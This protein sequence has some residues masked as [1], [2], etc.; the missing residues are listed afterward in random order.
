MPPETSIPLGRQP[1]R[2]KMLLRRECSRIMN[3]S[4]LT[5]EKRPD[6][7]SNS[8]VGRMVCTAKRYWNLVCLVAIG[9][10]VAPAVQPCLGQ[11]ESQADPAAENRNRSHFSIPPSG[12]PVDPSKFLP[13]HFE[14]ATSASEALSLYRKVMQDPTEY[15]KK[16]NQE[17]LE[18]VA[19]SLLNGDLKLDP[20]DPLMR[21]LMQELNNPDREKLSPGLR[22]QLEIVR[23]NSTSGGTIAPNPIKPDGQQAA[24]YPVGSSQPATSASNGAPSPSSSAQGLSGQPAGADQSAQSGSAL[25]RWL[26]RQAEGLAAKDG[27][28]RNSPSVQRALEEFVLSGSSAP[29]S[30]APDSF[31]EMLRGVLPEDWWSEHASERFGDLESMILSHVALPEFRLPRPA[32]PSADVA[33]GPEDLH[34]SDVPGTGATLLWFLA[35]LALGLGGWSMYRRATIRKEEST[36]RLATPGAWP[37]APEAVRSFEDFIQAF[38]H[39]S[40]V[41]LGPKARNWNHRTIALELGGD[42]SRRQ[43]MAQHLARLYEQARY[44]PRPTRF[45]ADALDVAQSELVSLAGTSN[46]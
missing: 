12:S 40:L 2:G 23:R 13:E 25:N 27:V 20:N 29:S 18:Q 14:H 3:M 26:L 32:L 33:A 42:E 44:A 6:L 22:Q 4:R 36:N 9:A 7:L 1:W 34:I 24:Q 43:Q 30:D 5:L 11:R 38:E 31:S 21:I 10:S 45:A 35:A 17:T 28:L 8:R 41:K 37:V 16:Q 39:L 15:L 19:V 46:A